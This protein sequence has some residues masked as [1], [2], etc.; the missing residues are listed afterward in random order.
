MKI[1]YITNA[2]L[3]T[4][5]AHGVQIVKMTEA[6]SSLNNEVMIISPKRVQ[7]EISHK[8]DIFNFY[9]IQENF[10]HML[11]EFIDPYVYRPFMPKFIYRFF[12]FIV[13]ILWG[14]KSAK[15]GSKVKG[16]LY[17]FRD[18]TPFSYLFSAIKSKKCV[19]EFHDI[20]P[21]TSRLIFKIGLIFSKKTICFAVTRTLS[22]DLRK[23]LGNLK[24]LDDIYTL[25]DGVDLKKFSNNEN[26]KNDVPVLTYCGSLSESK[27]IDLIIQTAKLIS[28]VNFLIVGGLNPELKYYQKVAKD[29]GVKNISFIGQVNYSD[30][31]KLLNESDFLL[32]PSSASNIKSEKYTSAMKLF[33]YLSIGKP[34]I[35]SDIPS[36]TEILENNENC[37]LFKPDNSESFAEQIR[38][39]IQN[40]Q[41]QKKISTNSIKLASMY[42]WEERSKIILEKIKN[43]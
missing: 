37:L 20:P 19:V 36:N 24:N 27:G 5:K 7:R 17:I 11:V 6:F 29:N 35:A 3:P 40:K 25:H 18:N 23:K 42:S 31:P 43:I 13:N 9:N 16:D 33:E 32:L 39:I 8:T 28:N 34:I 12:S 14:V 38:L 2:R 30:V 10:K 22:A 41:L 4:E 15:V 1:V 26:K 21:F